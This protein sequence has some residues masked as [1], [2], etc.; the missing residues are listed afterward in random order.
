MTIDYMDHDEP[1]GKRDAE[2]TAAAAAKIVTVNFHRDTLFAVERWDGVQIPITP[3]CNALGLDPM[4][5][6]DRIQ[7]DPILSEGG[8]WWPFPRPGASRI[9]SAYTL[10]L[11]TVGCSP[12][13]KVA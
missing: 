5:Q 12:L 13:M 7:R 2:A 3:I 4:R 1:P 6:R 10:N 11:C 9:R 8:P